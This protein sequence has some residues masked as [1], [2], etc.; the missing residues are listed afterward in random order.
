QV[1]RLRQTDDA[2]Q[3]LQVG[4]LGEGQF[5]HLKV[6]RAAPLQVLQVCLPRL[7]QGQTDVFLRY[8]HHA[9]ESSP[10]AEKTTQKASYCYRTS[11]RQKQDA[12]ARVGRGLAVAPA[13]R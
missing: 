5:Q 1:A 11:F 10:V 3:R 7:S 4:E 6:L 2:H 9:L 12:N 8:Q 13:D